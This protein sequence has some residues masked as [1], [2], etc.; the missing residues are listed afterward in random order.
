MITASC[1]RPYTVLSLIPVRESDL[2]EIGRTVVDNQELVISLLFLGYDTLEVKDLKKNG[3]QGKVYLFDLGAG[4]G[5]F[6]F[7]FLKEWELVG[8]DLV[9]VM[10]DFVEEN[11]KFLENH[12][13]HHYHL[14][15]LL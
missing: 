13:I 12:S 4:T 11:L 14:V 15:D 3:Y 1:G 6:G 5:R 10:T 7:L 9:Y 8:L 2:K